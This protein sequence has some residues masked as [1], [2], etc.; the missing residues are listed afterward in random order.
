VAKMTRTGQLAVEYIGKNPDET[1]RGVAR[2]LHNDHPMVFCSIDAA[3]GA[4]RYYRG[5]SGC[6]HRADLTDKRFVLPNPTKNNPLSLPDSKDVAWTPYT[7]PD[8]T[9]G[10]LVLSDVHFPYHDR[11]ALQ[12]ALEYGRDNG[13]DCIL[14]NGDALDCYSL[15]RYTTDPEK[16]NFPAELEC[17]RHGLMA[18]RNMFPDAKII[19]KEGNHEARFGDLL[20][21]KASDFYG[22]H[23]FQLRVLLGLFDMGIDYVCD[24][25]PIRY[26]GLTILHGHEMPTKSGGVNPARTALLKTR[27]CVLV[28]HFHRKT[29]DMQKVLGGDYLQAWSSGCLSE[30]HPQYMP[31]NDWVHG[32]AFV[33][34]GADWVVENKAILDGVIV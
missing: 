17:A 16:R 21:T 11:A 31:I 10:I 5:A 18:I 9:G 1:T 8:A 14:L 6:E 33:R 25:R 34:G 15:S 4:V 3:R 13:A 27:A 24:K 32:F 7:I 28:G 26:R 20:K 30:L 22:V 2:L 19:Y 12:S 29:G 23:E